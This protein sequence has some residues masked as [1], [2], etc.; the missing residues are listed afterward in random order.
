MPIKALSMVVASGRKDAVYEA[1][2]WHPRDRFDPTLE[3]RV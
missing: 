3:K 1:L 2:A